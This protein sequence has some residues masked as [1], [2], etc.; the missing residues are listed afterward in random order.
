M[1]SSEGDYLKFTE[2]KVSGE[3]LRTIEEMELLRPT[4]IQAKVIP[5]ALEGRTS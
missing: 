1:Y 4:Y 2:F 5:P 3:T